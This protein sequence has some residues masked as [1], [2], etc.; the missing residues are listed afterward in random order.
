M[1][2]IQAVG[3]INEIC[4]SPGMALHAPMRPTP[5]PNEDSYTFCPF[6]DFHAVTDVPDIEMIAWYKA[7]PLPEFAWKRRCFPSK[8]M[9][10]PPGAVRP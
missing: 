5:P 7:R 1:L 8:W 10:G 2:L 9:S 3:I 6:H 4:S